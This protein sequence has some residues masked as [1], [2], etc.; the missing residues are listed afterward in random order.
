MI[1]TAIIDDIFRWE[2]RR[3]WNDVPNPKL[4]LWLMLNPSTADA[5]KDD[6]TLLRIIKWGKAWGYDGAIVVNLYP[7][8]SPSPIEL[9]KW[10]AAGGLKPSV[11]ERNR[12][13]TLAAMKECDWE[14]MAGWGGSLPKP[15]GVLTYMRTLNHRA[16]TIDHGWPIWRC[17]G[18]SQG[19]MPI[20][21]M[22]RGRNR[23]PDDA[24][25]I[26]YDFVK[27]LDER[28]AA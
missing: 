11:Y 16:L 1:R 15:E 2:L 6:P 24:T 5:E 10:H 21:P 25:P 8:R 28:I 19:G 18:V 13:I 14:I 4:I 3:I 26:V 27:H 9:K 12:D 17:L 22:A 23:I 20:H 7:F